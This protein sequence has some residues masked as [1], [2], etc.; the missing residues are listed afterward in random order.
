MQPGGAVG[1]FSRTL[2]A[3]VLTLASFAA[4]AAAP[5]DP[6]PTAAVAQAAGPAQ[7]GGPPQAQAPPLHT[8]SIDTAATFEA[9]AVP[10]DGR[11]FVKFVIDTQADRI[12]Y[13]WTGLFPFHYHFVNEVLLAGTDKAYPDIHAFNAA[14]H[15]GDQRPY[16]LG[17]LVHSSDDGDLYTFQYLEQDRPTAAIVRLTLAKLNATFKA[18]EVRLRPLVPEHWALAETLED[19]P[20][21]QRPAGDA[22]A[23]PERQIL[24]K[25]RAVGRLRVVPAGTDFVHTRFGAD[26]IVLLPELPMDIS[27]VAGI[28]CAAFSTPLSHVNLRARAWGIPNVALAT[29]PPEL[30]GLEGR[31]VLL[32]AESDAVRFRE[33]TRA[34]VD[35]AAAARE[36]GRGER[37][38]PRVDLERRGMPGLDELAPSDAPSVGAKAANLGGLYRGRGDAFDV[39]PGFA[40]PFS[41]FAE[42]LTRNHLRDALT[43]LLSDASLAS[44]A[45]RCQRLEAL[46][47]RIRAGEHDP[48]FRAS[49]AKR[50]QAVAPAGEG[51]FVRSS[52]NAEDLAGFSGAGLYDTV[53]N[54]RGLDKVLAAVTQVWASTLN[55]RAYDERAFWNIEHTAVWPAVLVQR[56][57]DAKAAGVLVTQDLTG[58]AK[59]SAVTI[60]AKHGLGL[61][62]V[63]G[64]TLPEQV[65]VD[66]QT[67]ALHVTS[68]STERRALELA[69][70]GGVKEVAATAGSKVLDEATVRAL[71]RAAKATEA[72]FP[73][74]GPLDIEWVLDRSGAVL[75]VQVRPYVVAPT[76]TP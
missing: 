45:G 23:R 2:L 9:L 3:L 38:I 15:T 24:N 25:G 61:L 12:H 75:L 66:R 18:G 20:C 48:A 57:A 26:E 72:L 53:P 35:E 68:R 73:D 52:T 40:V 28:V 58:Q 69:A 30:K 65:V 19:V 21:V 27:P 8:G 63:D 13:L 31:W 42:F 17:A 14:N 46:Q 32:E 47:R 70:G 22:A 64:R 6:W 76:P 10:L 67:G 5:G 74:S 29:V 37:R 41:H 60:N 62:V 59:G 7:P 49:L 39:P 43:R 34:E 4:A 56:S 71:D 54:V 44:D 55:C 1:E 33:A 16:V 51:V 36:R 50:L 11:S